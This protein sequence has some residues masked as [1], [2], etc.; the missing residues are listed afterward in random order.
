MAVS[1]QWQTAAQADSYDLEIASD[2][3][4]TTIVYQVAD[5]LGTSHDVAESTFAAGNTYYWRVQAKNE[6][7]TGVWSDAWSFNAVSANVAPSASFTH[8]ETDLTASFTDTSTDSDGTIASWAWDF[9]DGNTSTQQHPSHTYAAGGTYTVQLTVTDDQGASDTY[10]NGVTVAEPAGQA[11]TADFS[12]VTDDLQAAF[13]SEATDPDSPITGFHWDFGD[14][15]TSTLQDPVHTYAADGT[16]TVTFTVTDDTGLT[17]SIQKA[18][19]VAAD[20]AVS[21]DDGTGRHGAAFATVSG[22]LYIVGGGHVVSGNPTT[23][24]YETFEYDYAAG[25]F[26]GKTNTP[27]GRFGG[28]S[29]AYNGSIYSAGGWVDDQKV[30]RYDPATDTH[31]EIGTDLFSQSVGGETGAM[32]GDILYVTG[33][34]SGSTH[35][36]NHYA[37]DVVAGTVTQLANIPVGIAYG[38]AAVYNGKYYV[39]GGEDDGST[40]NKTNRA[41]CYDPGTDAWTEVTSMPEERSSTRALAHNGRMYVPGGNTN[42]GPTAGVMSYDP[43][44]DSWRTE[45]ALPVGVTGPSLGSDG[46]QFFVAGGVDASGNT[47]D[48]VQAYTPPA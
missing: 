13:T 2:A 46:S 25:A 12:V 1:F 36:Q 47:T 22:K 29:G 24:E 41:F 33:G 17:D 5:L 20:Y 27:V 8:S 26:T 28:V 3:A 32:L 16:Y 6:S 39:F 38:C 9:G 48:L 19:H 18:V 35:I 23:Y 4:F 31:V 42:G 7:G 34:R 37:I 15:N 45:T 43:V 40:R 44:A 10:S 21:E 11:P 14:G 30:Y